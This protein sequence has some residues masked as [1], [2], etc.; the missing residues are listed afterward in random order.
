MKIKLEAMSI[1]LETEIGNIIKIISED[2]KLP[3]TGFNIRV[4]CTDKFAKKLHIFLF[5][6]NEQ[7]EELEWDYVTGNDDFDFD[8]DK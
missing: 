8:E 6:N 7:I 4:I 5:K 2:K 1:N 3:F